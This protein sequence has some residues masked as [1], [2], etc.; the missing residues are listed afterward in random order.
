MSVN[1]EAINKEMKDKSPAEIVAW[2]IKQG[3]KPV[4]TTNFRPY[5]SAILHVVAQV[6]PDVPVIWADSGYNTQAT[7]KFAFKV[8]KDLKLNVFTYIPQ[9]TAAYRNA[10][11]DGIPGIDSPLHEEFTKQVKLE[12][13]KRAMAEHKPDIWFT[14]LRQE[15]TEFRRS[16]NIIS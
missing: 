14:N 5:E 15:Q 16:L 10:L 9:Q 6:K 1:V 7:Y 13:F 3:K 4:V 12:P 11:M 2:A 8:I